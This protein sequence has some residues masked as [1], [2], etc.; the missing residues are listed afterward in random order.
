[1]DVETQLMCDVLPDG[2]V[3]ATVL[4]EPVYDTSS[5]ARIATRITDPATGAPYTPV[6]EIQVCPTSP[7]CESPTTPVTSVGLCLADGTPIAVTITRDCTGATVSEGWLNLSTGAWSAG[8]VPA[9]TVACGDT[10]SI[11]VSGT[12]CDVDAA[13]DV[14]GLVLVE[15]TYDDTGAIASVRLVD[16]VTGGTYTPTGTVTV[17]PA[18]VEQPERDLVQLCDTATDGTVTEFVR[19][20]ARDETGA[21]VGHTDYGL[22]GTPYTPTGS[23]GVCV[24]PCR[25]T[26]VLTLCDT[27]PAGPLDLASRLTFTN[28]ADPLPWTIPGGG[29]NHQPALVSGQPFWDGGTVTI[30]PTAA[31]ETPEP[32]HRVISAQIGVQGAAQLCDPP[33]DVTLTLTADILNLGPGAGQA[34]CGRW[35]L[36]NG[37]TIV[38]SQAATSTPVN[39]VANFSI[40]GTVPWADILAGQVHIAMDLETTH[41]GRKSWEVSQFEVTVDPAELEPCETAAGEA[42]PFL[43]T[44]VI[45]CTGA[46]VSVTDTTLDGQPY[47]AAGE[48]GQCQSSGGCCDGGTTEPCRDTSTVLVCDVPADSTTVVTPTIVDGVSADTGQ[49]QFQDHPGPYTDLWSGGTFVY[50]A[51]VGPTQEHL[52]ATGQ[53]TADMAACDGA[54]G[55]VTISVRVRNDGP[56]EGQAW[57]GALRLFRGTTLIASHNALEW[58]PPGWQGTLTVSAP[59]TAADIAAGDIRVALTLETYHLGA[60]A[61]TADQFTAALELEGCE[62]T[63]STQFLRTLV[64]DCETG[65]VVSTTDTTLDGQPYTVTGEVGQCTPADSGSSSNCRDCEQLVLCD[66][67]EEGTHS[68]LRVVCRDCT[69]AVI[70]VLDTELDGTTPYTVAGTPGR[71]CDTQVVG[72]CTYS[73]PDTFTAFSLTDPAYPGCWLGTGG[74]ASYTYGDRVTSWAATYMT[75]TGSASVALFS[76]PD[77]GGPIDFTAFTPALPVNPAQSAAGYTGT[78]VINGVTVTLTATG[79]NGLGI[80]QANPIGL[81]LGGDDAF[82][83]DFSQSVLLTVNASGFADPPTLHERF[84]GV[85]AVTVPWPALKLADCDGNITTVDPDTREPIPAGAT[86]ECQAPGDDC[87]TTSVQT[88]RLCDLDPTVEPDDDGRRCAVPFLRHLAYD[89]AGDLLGFHDTGLDGTT[90]YVP[91]QVVDCQCASGQGV[92]SSIE[93]PWTVVSVVEDPAGTPQQDFIYTVAPETDPSRVGTIRVH[94]SRPAGGACGAYDINNLVFSNTSAYTLTLDDV[95]QEMSYLRVDLRDFDTFEPVGINSG[96]PQPTRLGGTAGWNAAHTRIVPSENDGTGYMYWDNPPEVVSWTVFNAGGGTSCSAL[97]FQ[98]MTVEPGG[99]CGEDDGCSECGPVDTGVR[100]VTGTAAQD[101]VGEFPDLQSVSLAVLAG[102]V[103]VTASDGTDVPI[104]A[105]VTLTWSVSKDTD[106]AL[107]AAS[108]AGADASASYLLNWTRA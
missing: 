101:L 32:L 43:R 73:L 5:G 18:G 42:I 88:I 56:S 77:L 108:F 65:E 87:A 28:D 61:W 80:W 60:K 92:T 91:T 37:A 17:C 67:T 52:T 46:T 90:P 3:A 66:V 68:F 4:V 84:C 98:G 20:Y 82:R 53:L 47:T 27:V 102:V 1:M 79:G 69:G 62:A 51:G 48:V 99:C 54:S 10:R 34:T 58:A 107:A 97:S 15:Y 94:V 104:P 45:D 72:E 64:T 100:S 78:A 19:D 22:D 16:A 13:G 83:L 85:T 14:V 103:N 55:T 35:H 41:L 93:V 50:P 36:H 23:V 76:S 11:Q 44:V 75:D 57:D 7:D 31:T 38:T 24:D 30:A 33:T 96:S 70:S 26:S 86:V 6:G 89:C 106:T 74:A 40:T 63:S 71:C 105:G 95:A 59:V 25:T 39:G 12:F 2:T 9:G 49:T 21:I 8:T 29:V 81:Y